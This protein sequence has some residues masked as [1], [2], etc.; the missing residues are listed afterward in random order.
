MFV[1]LCVLYTHTLEYRNTGGPH[2]RT[3]VDAHIK[4][5]THAAHKDPRLIFRD[6]A[7]HY[8][9]LKSRRAGRR[10]PEDALRLSPAQSQHV[11]GELDLHPGQLPVGEELALPLHHLLQRAAE[12]GGRDDGPPAVVDLLQGGLAE[13]LEGREAEGKERDLLPGVCVS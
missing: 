4:K 9:S 8:S 11:L 1:L 2:T 6:S 12:Q 5:S 3:F 13:A 10:L 7:S